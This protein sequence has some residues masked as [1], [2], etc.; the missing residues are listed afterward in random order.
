MGYWLLVLA[1]GLF[2]PDVVA[3]FGRG[4][5]ILIVV[6]GFVAYLVVRLLGVWLRVKEMEHEARQAAMVKPPVQMPP[7]IPELVKPVSE[8]ST[9]HM[10]TSVEPTSTCP[11]TSPEVLR[12]CYLESLI[13]DCRR[14]RLIG[15]DPSASD[16]TRG[17]MTLESLYV[18]LD[19]KTQ[20][21]VEQKEEKRER[22]LRSQERETR[23]LT[24][25]E[26]LSQAPER[27]M[28]L[29]GLPGAGKIDACAL[30][31][32]ADGPGVDRPFAQS[33]R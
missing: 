26:A 28:V 23:P 32:L 24:A 2:A 15:L 22:T 20:I 8:L 12:T 1:I 30:S 5:F 19:T 3:L 17:G 29:L 25:L 6:L 10:P 33:G 21:D 14:A 18:A 13:G 16:P 27:R 9:P 4:F 7:Q 31:D 11:P